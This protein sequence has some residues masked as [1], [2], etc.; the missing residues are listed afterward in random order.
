MLKKF[1]LIAVAGSIILAHCTATGG[2]HYVSTI[3][4][5][6]ALDAMKPKPGDIIC[7]VTGA[8]N[9]AGSRG[10]YGYVQAMPYFIEKFLC[11]PD[12]NHHVKVILL[13]HWT[14][15]TT[16]RYKSSDV[17]R[18]LHENK[19]EVFEENIYLV[20]EYLTEKYGYSS[21]EYNEVHLQNY[22]LSVLKALGAVFLLE[23]EGVMR[24][25]FKKL[26]AEHSKNV[27]YMRWYGHLSPLVSS[28]YFADSVA[29]FFEKWDVVD[30]IVMDG[31]VDCLSGFVDSLFGTCGR[32][33][34]KDDL[35]TAINEENRV[36]LLNAYQAQLT[37]SDIDRMIGKGEIQGED[38]QRIDAAWKDQK[39][40]H[41]CTVGSLIPTVLP[42]YFPLI[43]FNVE[44]VKG[45]DGSVVDVNVTPC[46]SVEKN[47]FK[48][49]DY[50]NKKSLYELSGR[51]FRKKLNEDDKPFDNK[52]K[53]RTKW[54]EEPFVL[55]KLSGTFDSLKRRLGMFSQVLA[56][57]K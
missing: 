12:L 2:P 47:P 27:F 22:L 17:Y 21:G 32:F 15:K 9:L 10:G 7:V 53:E 18:Y 51:S 37:E 13:D 3:K 52:P 44:L 26:C 46:I 35:L 57:Y 39:L 1:L 29:V 5:L 55:E 8:K 40:Q 43:D 19:L 23:I 33:G 30:F 24:G 28:G 14:D 25:T 11:Q 45:A 54:C 31:K 36:E 50:L 6:V 34:E 48:F 38:K 49:F 56:K 4:E 41:K 20:D 16:D 42:S